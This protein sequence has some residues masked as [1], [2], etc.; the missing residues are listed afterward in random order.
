[1][2]LVRRQIALARVLGR[3]CEQELGARA[4]VAVVDRSDGAV[5]D[6]DLMVPRNAAEQH[7]L[8][9]GAPGHVCGLPRPLGERP[10]KRQ[11]VVRHDMA[12]EALDDRAGADAYPVAPIGAR[13]DVANGRQG[14]HEVVGSRPAETRGGAQL[15]GGEAGRAAGNLV[16]ESGRARHR[17]DPRLDRPGGRRQ[18][19]AGRHLA[20]ASTI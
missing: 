7:Q 8:R 1:M 5:G 16:E 4:C 19:L 11:E 14:L 9:A 6:R 18:F 10:R 2:C 15:L 20:Y 3:Q 13:G 12:L 17:L